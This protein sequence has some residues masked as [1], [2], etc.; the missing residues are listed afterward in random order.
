MS[1]DNALL[2]AEVFLLTDESDNETRSFLY[3]QI[4]QSLHAAL[5][6]ARACEDPEPVRAVEWALIHLLAED[7]INA[8]VRVEVNP[9][10]RD[11]RM[12]ARCSM[13]GRVRWLVETQGD[14]L[15]AAANIL[16]TSPARTMTKTEL[17]D[18][19]MAIEGMTRQNANNKVK[20]AKSLVAVT[21]GVFTESSAR[22]FLKN[23]KPVR[24]R[25]DNFDF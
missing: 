2:R 15:R 24:G 1:I 10:A 17:V 20:R 25:N 6:H 16:R 3:A 14:R 21:P 22:E 8:P 13:F 12:A 5:N 23:Q 19:L 11:P 9:P 18:K 7:E 4:R